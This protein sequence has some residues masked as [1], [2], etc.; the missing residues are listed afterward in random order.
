MLSVI[1]PTR[2]RLDRVRDCLRTLSQLREP[3]GGLEVVVVDDGS[4]NDLSDG[5]A[6]VRPI[7][8]ELRI[9]RQAPGGLN[10]ARNNGA[11]ESRGEL[12]AFLDDDTLVHGGWAD[13]LVTA[14]AKTGCDAIGGRVMLRMEGPTPRWLTP[15]LRRYLAA[16]DLGD[17]SHW[18]HDEP[19]PVGANC[20]VRRGAFETAGGFYE[21]LDRSGASLLSN[22]DT[23]FFRRQ[24]R[25]G[26]RIWYEAGAL[27]EHCVPVDRL[28]R[29]FFYRR[30]RAQGRSDV[31]L[32]ALDT[33]TRRQQR[34]SR[35]FVRAGRSAP[36]AVRGLLT[37][38]GITGARCWVHYCRGRMAALRDLEPNGRITSQAFERD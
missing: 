31:L 28:T 13:A 24:R 9:I 23:E 26:G 22:G 6:N 21:G 32:V 4:R 20:A 2:D 36:I 16:Y 5:L 38:G 14:F 12:L 37:G 7:P 17:E 15:K 19:V 35:E 34:R 33:A 11:A 10:D 8:D 18:I 25:I 29:E 3:P 27:V 30:A 1:I